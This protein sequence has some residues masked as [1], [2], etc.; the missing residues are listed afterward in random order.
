VADDQALTLEITKQILKE[1]GVL[2]ICQFE[3]NGQEAINAAKILVDVALELNNEK[4]ATLRPITCML[5]DLQMPIKNG[6]EVMQET[7]M[8]Y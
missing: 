4:K 8:M 3:I 6:I 2:K 1:C 7:K 5:L